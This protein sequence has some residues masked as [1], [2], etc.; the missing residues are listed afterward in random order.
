MPRTV[1]DRALDPAKSLRD[2]EHAVIRYHSDRWY[3]RF[4][5]D[6]RREV[7]EVLQSI[8]E[9]RYVYRTDA[10]VLTFWSYLTTCGLV[11]PCQQCG[12]RRVHNE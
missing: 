5:V 10:F 8:A 12:R 3:R 2:H 9:Y 7:E 6:S 1:S 11:Q 4:V